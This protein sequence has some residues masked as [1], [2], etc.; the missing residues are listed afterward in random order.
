LLQGTYAHLAVVDFW[1]AR[2]RGGGGRRAETRFSRWRD[3]T[4]EALDTLA[5]SGALTEAG[6]RFV[7]GLRRALAADEVSADARRAA[8]R[9]AEEHRRTVLP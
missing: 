3:Q 8:H 7:A 5:G 9:V 4:A 6:E 2:W 1:L